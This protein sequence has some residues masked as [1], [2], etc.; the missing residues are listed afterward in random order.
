[1]FSKLLHKQ[2]RWLVLA[3]PY[4][5]LLL[6]F[7][8]PFLIV[9]KI[10][11]SSPELAMP[12]YSNM[13]LHDGSTVQ[14]V[15]NFENYLALF[16]DSLYL[17]SYLQSLEMAAISTLICLVIGYPLAWVIAHSEPKLRNILLMLVVLPSWTSSLL[18]I[19]A[20]MNIL[21]TNG[22]FNDVLLAL[23]IISEPL[24]LLHTNTAVYIGIV[25]NYLPFMVLPLY[26][27]IMK[28]DHTLI[29]AA[30]DLGARPLKVITSVVLPLTKSGIIAGSM[31]VFIPAVGEFMIPELLGGP[32][33]LL[34]GRVLWQE[35]FNN[36]DWPLAS[37]VAT[38]MLLL[39]VLPM[40]LFQRSQNEELRAEKK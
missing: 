2:G 23:G 13:F 33:N 8:V 4:V 38:T 16:R 39:L 32:D 18:R 27:A 6:F 1:M 28:L 30:A 12:P 3:V 31:L 26:S 11:L 34:I 10:S 22:P 35:F 15:L 24:E 7:L 40:L 37:A 14:I 9:F 29:E 19:Y 21:N 5:W 36:R 25:Y 17:N 20:W